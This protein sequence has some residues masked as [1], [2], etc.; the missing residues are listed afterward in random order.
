MNP[1]RQT[2]L[3]RI[4]PTKALK[5]LIR[6]AVLMLAGFLTVCAQQRD[7]LTPP[8]V[9]AKLIVGGSSFAD[10][11]IPHSVAGASVRFYITRRLSVEPEFLYMRHSRDDQDYIFQP[12]VAY[13]L[14]DP[15]KRF[16][17]YLIGGVG[18][19]YHRGRF[20][21]VDFTTR[22]PRVFDTSFTGVDRQCRCWCEDL[23]D[24]ASL[25]CP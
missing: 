24:Q 18:V 13:D 5:Y 9:E 1:T 15:T 7:E 14:T 6:V 10:P 2:R 11:A 12:N 3:P 22:Q 23:P 20:F 16:V 19:I 17:P 21:G 8:R 4:N 25:H